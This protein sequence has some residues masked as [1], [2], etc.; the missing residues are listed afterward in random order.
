[1]ER[2]VAAVQT[3]PCT[4]LIEQNVDRAVDLV[5]VAVTKGAQIVVL[6]ELF[7]TLFFPVGIV[8]NAERFFE[9]IPGPT[10]G[11]LCQ[12][13]QTQRC[14]IVAGIGERT[15][16][17]RYYNSVVVVDSKG[18]VVGIYRKTHL[19]LQ[20]TP[21]ERVTYEAHYFSRGDLGLPVFD[22]DGLKLGVLIC[23]DRHF[24]EAFRTLALRG[25]EMIVLPTGARTWNSGWRSG[26]WEALLRTRA[27]ENGTFIVAADKAGEEEGTQYLGDSMIVSPVGGTILARSAPGAL[28]DIV[29][30]KCDLSEA[31]D[32]RRSVPFF[33]DFRPEIYSSH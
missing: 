29:I 13:A 32:F 1:M 7:S 23:Y 9:P 14:A 10:T 17:G 25:A 15:T 22:V 31:R 33:R 6:P 3:G 28:D 12:I 26:I 18:V 2:I 21:P 19:P 5:E 24:P 30:A 11:R 16:A 4:D 8:D 27:Y 20:L